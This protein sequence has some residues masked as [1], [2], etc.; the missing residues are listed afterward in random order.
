MVRDRQMQERQV[1]Q[2]RNLNVRGHGGTIV[3]LT[4]ALA[5]GVSCAHRVAAPANASTRVNSVDHRTLAWK[6]ERE[7]ANFAPRDGAGS[8]VFDG[9]MWLIGGYNPKEASVKREVWN[10]VDGLNWSLVTDQA[11]WP[12]RHCAGYAV[13]K[14]KIWMVSGDGYADVWNSS[15]GATWALVSSDPPWGK[16]YKPYV[17]V[18]ANKLWLM[19]GM[20]Y[21]DEASPRYLDGFNDVWNTTDGVNWTRVVE[22]APW[23]PRGLIHGAAVFADKMWIIG[24]GHYNKLPR[25]WENETYYCDVWCSTDGL[26]WQLVCERAPWMPRI[27]HSVAVFDNKLWVLAGH[28]KPSPDLLND[29]WYSTDGVAWKE[30][31]GTPWSPRHAISLF[32]FRDSL[33]LVAGFLVNDVWRL[34]YRGTGESAGVLD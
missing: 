23:G 3:L 22:H 9:K 26:N 1:S 18:Y 12:G 7:H 21:A 32:V 11:P 30:L 28:N 4:I 19:G 31:P 2:E 17:I 33:W 29:V 10:S 13:Y 15:D 5:G 6:Q 8:V 34:D 25:Y 27:H 20:E 16:R 14:E 24:G